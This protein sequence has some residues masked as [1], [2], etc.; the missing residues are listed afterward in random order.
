MTDNFSHDPPTELIILFMLFGGRAAL[1]PI[2]QMW[3]NTVKTHVFEV[4]GV[5]LK[6]LCLIL[7]VK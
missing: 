2:L 4:R 1:H 7:S 6:R 3:Y 5:L